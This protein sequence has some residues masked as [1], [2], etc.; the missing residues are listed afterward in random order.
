M[1]FLHPLRSLAPDLIAALTLLGLLLPEAVAYASIAE[2]PPQAGIMALLVGLLSYALIGNSR[3]AIVSATSS[4][5][6][7]LAVATSSLADG[8]AGLRTAYAM[9]L[10]LTTGVFFILAASARLGR[11]TDF[12]A[13][14]VLQGFSFGLALV[15]V[16][17]QWAEVVG[18]HL[19]SGPAILQ[20]PYLL[21]EIEH[22]NVFGVL[23]A[24]FS[25]IFLQIAR[26][27]W[28]G[29]LLLVIV[30][31][32]ASFWLDFAALNIRQVGTV[33]LQMPTWELPHLAREEWAQ[34]AEL[35]LAMLMVLYAESYS[36]IRGAASA[37]GDKISPNRDL[38]ALGVAN[39]F[40]A[41][42][43]G[44]AVGAGFSATAAN[45]AAG[46]RSRW[47]GAIAALLV[48]SALYFVLP[49]LARIAQPV[50]AAIV[51]DALAHNLHWR[52]FVPYFV[53]RRD[54]I[55]SIVAVLAV[56]LLGV[57]HGLV[58]AVAVSMLL[59]LH[60]IGKS[61]LV[62]LGRLQ[63]SHDFVDLAQYP[64][65]KTIPGLLILRPDEPLFFANAER[66]LNHAK[67]L[68]RASGPQL[69]QVVFSLEESP[70]LD[71]SSV[72]ALL[73][74][75]QFLRARGQQL[76]F[77]RLKSAAREV[78]QASG[79]AGLHEESVLSV[80]MV[81]AAWQRREAAHVSS[82]IEGEQHS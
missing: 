37:H 6:A 79:I 72:Q 56:L 40:S 1:K 11:L 39:L 30:S 66:I 36:A 31:I 57:L 33:H 68:V 19:H 71:S 24:L 49:L 61:N 3:F 41:A 20:L 14:P 77:A 65:A 2:L 44:L 58:A 76:V 8:D 18:I 48:A 15:I 45:Q 47:A 51:I 80:D 52:Q 43:Q 32:A 70:D 29:G 81:V 23:L 50:L 10:V 38:F 35:A 42:C 53:W 73:Q 4:S 26:G 60:Q 59:L 63:D 75:A 74:F 7:V 64:D 25:L 28:P 55:I 27:R 46:A 16:V 17:R 13:R 69:R 67:H 34:V 78:L 12:I 9:A 54:R 21:K 5:A 82:K 22:W 62:Q